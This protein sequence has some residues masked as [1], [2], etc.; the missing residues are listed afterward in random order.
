MNNQINST[1]IAKSALVKDNVTIG[2]G[3][4]IWNFA[5]VYG[6]KIGKNC[7]VG[8]YVEIQNN[9]KI[10]NNVT[11]S[12]HSFLCSLVTI[13]DDVFI[14][15]GVMTI[16]DLFPPS[17]KRTGTDKHWK[18][19]AI[20]KGAVIGSNAT[21]LPVTIGENAIIAAGSVVTKDVAPNSVVMGNP[22][23]EIAKRQ[24]L[25]FENGEKAYEN[26]TS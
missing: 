15:H 17:W 21:I 4:K 12:S 23:K 3:T 2:E 9:V 16:N 22:A 11:I 18:K 20:K 6:C 7:K 19:T 1:K 24:D 13:E 25:K 5:N 14:G 26:S 8:P 10:G